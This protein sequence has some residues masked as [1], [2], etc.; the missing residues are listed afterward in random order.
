MALPSPSYLHECFIYEPET[1]SLTWKQRPLHH[2]ADES[3]QLRWNAR[4]AGKAAGGLRD[5]G[6]IM[7][8]L[9]WGNPLRAHRI[10]WAMQTGKWVKQIDH[11]NGHRTENRWSNLREATWQ[12]NHWNRG[13]S[14]R[15]LPRGVRKTPS[16]RFSAQATMNYKVTHLGTFDTAEEAHAV[17]RAHV[18]KERGEFFRAD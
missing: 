6:Y 13:P 11:K 17:W 3:Y 7:V 2:F 12:Q 10:I 18:V 1:G 5:N 4:W 14:G 16:G 9:G 8:M 15:E